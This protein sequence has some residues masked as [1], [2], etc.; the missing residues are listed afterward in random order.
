MM[1]GHDTRL[2]TF[3]V[4]HTLVVHMDVRALQRSFGNAD[5]GQIE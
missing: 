4:R 2:Y 5:A 1:D 3:L